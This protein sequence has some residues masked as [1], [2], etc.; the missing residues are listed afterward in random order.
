MEDI[1]EKVLDKIKEILSSDPLEIYSAEEETV[2]ESNFELVDS[3][4]KNDSRVIGSANMFIAAT[5]AY[6]IK[7]EEETVREFSEEELED[8]AAHWNSILDLLKEQR[9]L[10][11]IELLARQKIKVVVDNT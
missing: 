3:R 1:P 7:I 8:F 5:V 11:E 9:F 10:R 6:Y 4:D 2:G